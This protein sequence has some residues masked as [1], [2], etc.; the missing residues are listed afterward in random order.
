[1]KTWRLNC[2][3]YN[4][5]E[6]CSLLRCARFVILFQFYF[7]AIKMQKNFK[8]QTWFCWGLLAEE[9]KFEPV[10]KPWLLKGTLILLRKSESLK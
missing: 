1:M 5:S 4:Y 7:F 6:Q 10:T 2:I 9:Y 8:L 3:F